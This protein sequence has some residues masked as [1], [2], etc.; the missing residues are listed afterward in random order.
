MIAPRCVDPIEFEPLER[1]PLA[2]CHLVYTSGDDLLGRT[3][4]G[5][6]RIRV[7]D[8]A[9]IEVI[10]EIEFV[11]LGVAAEVIVIIDKEDAARGRRSARP[12]VR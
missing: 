1:L 3:P 4:R 7:R 5:H 10:A 2:Q 9:Q 12:R 11:A 6:H 8:V